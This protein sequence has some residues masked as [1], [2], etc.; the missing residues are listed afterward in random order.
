MNKHA[1]TTST[2]YLLRHAH[3]AWARPG[4]RDFDRPLDERGV[5]DA[6]LVAAAFAGVE[7]LPAIILCSTARRCQQTCEIIL[8]HLPNSPNVQ[9]RDEL[10]SNDHAYYVELL[11]KQSETPVLLIGHNPMVED[12]AR[13]L[14]SSAKNRAAERLQKG[15]PTAGLASIEFDVS[16]TQIKDGGHLAEFLSPKR[17]RK[18][19]LKFES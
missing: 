6:N 16:M 19:A 7:Q 18:K 1:S 13:F 9:S 3:S 15:F 4:Q 10:Y 12:T 14:S 8:S 17:L 11:S 2:V 5:G